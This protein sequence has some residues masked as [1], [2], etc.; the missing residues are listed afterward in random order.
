MV[1]AKIEAHN[2]GKICRGH[3]ERSW[4]KPVTYAGDTVFE[5]LD[6]QKQCLPDLQKREGEQGERRC[7]TQ[8]FQTRT[9]LLQPLNPNVLGEMDWKRRFHGYNRAFRTKAESVSL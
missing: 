3:L 5:N 2:L 9:L 1:E 8:C 6:Q 4:M 7:P